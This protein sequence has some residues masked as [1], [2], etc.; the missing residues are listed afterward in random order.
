MCDWFHDN[1]KWDL[2]VSLR[3]AYGGFPPSCMLCLLQKG[4]H[5]HD[6]LIIADEA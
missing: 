4:A 5:N 6:T 2:N 1:L 3:L